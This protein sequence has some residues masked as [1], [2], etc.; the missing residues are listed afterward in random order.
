MQHFLRRAFIAINTFK[1]E[2]RPQI[3]NLALQLKE[4][5]IKK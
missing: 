4:L 2:E 3:N 1:K 5:E